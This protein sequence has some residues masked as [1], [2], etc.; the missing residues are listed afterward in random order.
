MY[1]IG[2]DLGGTKIAVGLVDEN[3]KI[4]AKEIL[5]TLAYRPVEEITF[6]IASL[7]QKVCKKENVSLS[8][9]KGIGLAIP[10]TVNTKTGIVE[11]SNNI[12]F[13]NFPIVDLMSKYLNLPKSL[14]KI[15]NDANLAAYGESVAGAGKNANSC[16]V[17]TLG[18]GVGGGIIIDG[19]VITGCSYGGAE[20]GHMV[21]EYN[22][23]QCTCGRKGCFE[24]YCSA[25]ALVDMTKEKFRN[26]PN[27][28]MRNIC[29]NDIN[30]VG[31]KTAFQAMYK[32][33]VAG[34]E[35][36]DTY[37][38]YLACGLVNII[39]IFQPE[40]LCIGGGV[41]NEGPIL[42]DMLL[43][44]IKDQIFGKG[45]KLVTKIS[46]AKLGNEAGIIGAAALSY[47]DN[48]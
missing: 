19:K 18:T 29:D 17:I 39:N 7:C 13:F 36:V 48:E 35:V 44:L 30:K 32:G 2:V 24:A 11:Y 45:N 47:S 9:L 23:R 28:L 10:G 27:S 42:I 14:F 16:V 1:S 5:P 22:G 26:N 40:V 15:G 33:D 25:T 6:D 21:I 8:S 41:S 43:P 38:S 4:V 46:L 20:L 34:K 31:G 3:H 12:K 37:L